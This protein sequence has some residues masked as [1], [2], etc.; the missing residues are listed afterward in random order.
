[1]KQLEKMSL[2][3]VKNK[4]T[5]TEMSNIM[6]GSNAGSID[7]MYAVDFICCTCKKHYYSWYC[8]LVYGC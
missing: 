2:A 8:S 1:M 3:N 5:R 7:C 4:L 6:A